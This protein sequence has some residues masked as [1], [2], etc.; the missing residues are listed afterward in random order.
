MISDL[1]QAGEKFVFDQILLHPELKIWKQGDSIASFSPSDFVWG[2]TYHSHC[3]P[4][5]KPESVLI[6][7]Y[8]KGQIA[9]L[10]RKVYGKDI[11]V[12]GVDLVSQDYDYIEYKVVNEDAYKFV[13]DCTNSIIKKRYDY[14]IIDLFD[15][16]KVPDFVFDVEF[17]VRLKEMTKRLICINIL[18]EDFDR[19][20][21]Y[22]EYGFNFHRLV[23][24]FGN[25]VSFWGV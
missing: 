4:P 20:R 15:G 14:I 8:G 18:A 23:P 3:I 16:Y 2:Y 5:F 9:E 7:G 1:F 19:L 22:K 24:I 17:V 25:I 11:K 13:K 6:L 21:P 10:I 12:T